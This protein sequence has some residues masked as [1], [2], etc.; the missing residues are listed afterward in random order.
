M[1]WCTPRHRQWSKRH[2]NICLCGSCPAEQCSFRADDHDRPVDRFFNRILNWFDGKPGTDRSFHNIDA[3]RHRWHADGQPRCNRDAVDDRLVGHDRIAKSQQNASRAR[4][5]RH[6]TVPADE[7]FIGHYGFAT[8][9]RFVG[10]ERVVSNDGFARHN[11][12][13]VDVAIGHA[14][15]AGRRVDNG[16]KLSPLLGQRY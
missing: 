2:E 1:K 6:D 16:S 14:I 11:R 7:R 9:E 5:D 10:L 12:R 8:D 4:I 3:E 15:D 13:F